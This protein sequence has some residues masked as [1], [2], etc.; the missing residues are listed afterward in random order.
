MD[1]PSP[2]TGTVWQHAC[3][4][5]QEVVAGSE[6]MTLECMKMEMSVCAPCGGRITWLKPMGEAIVE[7]ETVAIIEEEE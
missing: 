6:I 2:I 7:G 4:V 5:G 1:V 3:G